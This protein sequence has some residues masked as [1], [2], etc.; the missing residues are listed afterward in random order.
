MK[1]LQPTYEIIKKQLSENKA[2]FIRLGKTNIKI[3][4]CYK[5]KKGT[6]FALSS[7]GEHR[8]DLFSELFIE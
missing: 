3:Q 6:T 4:S 2:V 7:I 5:D 8:I 1:T